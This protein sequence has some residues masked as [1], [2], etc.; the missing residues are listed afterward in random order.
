MILSDLRYLTWNGRVSWLFYKIRR[1]FIA[2]A[3]NMD[4]CVMGYPVDAD[5]R[6]PR[7][8]VGDG[9]WCKRHQDTRDGN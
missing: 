8:A 3:P 9:M 4:R 5:V 6:C 2:P 7:F 1:R